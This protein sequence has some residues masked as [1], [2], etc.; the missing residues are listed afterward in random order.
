VAERTALPTLA[1]ASLA[2]KF[3]PRAS[4]LSWSV[5]SVRMN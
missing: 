5:V 1:Y 3:S 4:A 2:E